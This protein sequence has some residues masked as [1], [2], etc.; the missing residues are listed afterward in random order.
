MTSLLMKS[1][2]ADKDTLHEQDQPLKKLAYVSN[3]RGPL[4]YLTTHSLFQVWSPLPAPLPLASY[5]AVCLS[6]NKVQNHGSCGSLFL[7]LPIAILMIGGALFLSK[8]IFLRNAIRFK[9][10]LVIT[11]RH[12]EANWRAQ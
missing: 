3:H 11:I 2:S 6:K 5:L 12:S 8:I 9:P 4:L 1:T 10:Y 7:S